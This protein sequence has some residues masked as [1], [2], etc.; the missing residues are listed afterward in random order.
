MWAGVTNP[1]LSLAIYQTGHESVPSYP[2]IYYRGRWY[3]ICSAGFAENQHGAGS[4][5]NRLGFVSGTQSKTS[6]RMD[7]DAMPVGQCYP[8]EKLNKCTRGKNYFGNLDGGGGACKRARGSVYVAIVCS[9]G[10]VPSFRSSRTEIVFAGEPGVGNVFPSTGTFGIRGSDTPPLHILPVS[11]PASSP[12][13]SSLMFVQAI[14]PQTAVR[15]A[16][17][18]TQFGRDR[19]FDFDLNTYF[20][21]GSGADGLGM[22]N[23]PK[24]YIDFPTKVEIHQVRL[25]CLRG[26][27]QGCGSGRYRRVEALVGS[28]EEGIDLVFGKD[29]VGASG[30]TWLTWQNPDKVRSITRGRADHHV[31]KNLTDF[32]RL[33]EMIHVP[34]QCLLDKR[35]ALY[36]TQTRRTSD[37]KW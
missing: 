26:H 14:P 18:T 23:N 2:E 29:A 6:V 22:S 28:R 11:T 12:F 10:A 4:F 19:M 20:Q 32:H 8:N 1:D 13:S 27:A 7:R 25:A 36:H 33:F 24:V 3:P 21:S 37:E 34:P 9:G 30:Q 31:I 35:N 15:E 5:C 16:A 17:T